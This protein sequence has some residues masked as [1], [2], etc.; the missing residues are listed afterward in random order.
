[1]V[2]IFIILGSVITGVSAV[3]Q[4]YDAEAKDKVRNENE[5]KLNTTIEGLKTE[6]SELSQ[7]LDVLRNDNLNLSHQLTET[8]LKLHENV[9]GESDLEIEISIENQT[10]FV[11]RLVNNSDLPVFNALVTIQNYNEIIKCPII[12]ET[13][14]NIYIKYE[15]YENNFVQQANL[16]FNPHSALLTGKLFKITDD[17]LNF[18]I[19]VGTR[20]KTIIYHCVF[21]NIDGVF[22]RSYQKFDLVNDRKIFISE[23]NPLKLKDSYWKENFYEKIL[24]YLAKEK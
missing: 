7:K 10:H 20:K 24:Y 1:M 4:Y 23:E 17:Y 16:N 13:E 19:Q 8:S 6:N 14:E 2:L 15:C 11:L 21:K 18:A 3:I 22:V 5:K 9:I 12:N